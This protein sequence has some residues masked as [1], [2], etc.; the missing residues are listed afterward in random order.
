MGSGDGK[1]LTVQLFCGIIRRASDE[2]LGLPQSL[3]LLPEGIHQTLFY[4]QEFN[5]ENGISFL[6]LETKTGS[7]DGWYGEFNWANDL[8]NEFK[9][10][11][12]NGNWIVLKSS[13]PGEFGLMERT[14]HT[15]PA[16]RELLQGLK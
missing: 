13:R 4:F 3:N 12:P 6:I 10:E 15:N 9:K 1:R 8:R 5:M 7:A 16:M 2:Y 11:Y 14:V